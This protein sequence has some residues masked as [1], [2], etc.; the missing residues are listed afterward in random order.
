MFSRLPAL[1]AASALALTLLT[2]PSRADVQVPANVLDPKTAVEAWNVFRLA[3][4]N[5]ERLLAEERLEEVPMQISYT[6]PSIRALS[7]MH[8]DPDLLDRMEDLSRRALVSV[9]AIATSA[10]QKNPIGAKA[11]LDSLRKTMESV[12][13]HFEARAVKADVFFCAAHP[14]FLSEEPDGRCAKCGVKLHTR[15]IPYSLIYTKPNEPTVKLAATSSPIEAGKTVEVKLLMTKADKSPLLREDL[16]LTHSEPI[17]L[18]LDEPGLTDYHRIHPVPTKTP[19][20]YAFSFTP[21]K[22]D[23]YRIWADIMPASTG[24]QELPYVDLP[25]EG[26]P[27]K[28]ENTEDRFVSVVEGIQFTLALEKGNHLPL[29]AHQSRRASVTVTDAHG[30]PIAKLEPV[31]NA[32]AHLVGFYSDYVTVV[33]FHATGGDV[34]NPALRGGPSMGFILFPPK[35]GFVRLYCQVMIEGKTIF[36]PFNLNVQP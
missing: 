16:I 13:E 20:E 18:L 26:K 24:V 27:G 30:K 8:T 14:D 11:A 25:A 15:R 3:T 34:L 33:H 29:K 32:F 28:V 10:Q 12:A 2:S 22:S 4:S 23:T 6:S 35:P 7:R 36:A 1:L 31:M 9:N 17:H 5:V 19:G 21:R